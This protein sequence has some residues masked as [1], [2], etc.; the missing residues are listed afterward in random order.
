MNDKALAGAAQ[1]FV[2]FMPNFNSK[3][4][5]PS[6]MIIKMNITPIQFG[7]MFILE[8]DNSRSMSDIARIIGVKKQQLTL[9]ID[10][11]V[12]HGLVKRGQKENDRRIITISLSDSGKSFIIKQKNILTDNI[13]QMLS[14]LDKKQLVAL[15]N[16]MRTVNKI[17]EKI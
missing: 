10:G 13:K 3:M 14:R 11:L 9:L 8:S 4:K 12:R 16:S 15:N 7:I 2:S 1:E 17:L 5:R 6:E